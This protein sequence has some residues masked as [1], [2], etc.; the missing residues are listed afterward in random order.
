MKFHRPNRHI[1]DLVFPIALLAVFALS[2]LLTIL[3][4]ADVYRTSTAKSQDDYAGTISL[5]YISEKIRQNDM[6][7][8]ITIG[9]LETD[10][11]LIFSQTINQIPYI[12]YVYEH[13][14][15]LKELFIKEGSVPSP[16]TGKDIVPISDFSVREIS[17]R[18]F[19][20]TVVTE[21]GR[22]DSI[23][24]GMHSKNKEERK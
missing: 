1:I 19:K 20:V 18:L 14:G 6:N 11:C 22:S 21:A 24:I 13:E 5:S 7:G 17:E 3:I 2:A 23:V 16:E 8:A 4:A 15:M 10:A 12:T 9:T